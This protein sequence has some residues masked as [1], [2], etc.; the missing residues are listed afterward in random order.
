IYN[1]IVATSRPNCHLSGLAGLDQANI[2]S[3]TV[4][5]DASATAQYGARGSNGVILI[6]TKS[7]R[8]GKT[9]FSINSTYG[10]QNDAITGPVPLTAAER[11]ELLSE[12]YYNDGFFGSKQD[13]EAFLLGGSHAEWDANG[14]PEARWDLAVANR[15]AIIQQHNF[16]A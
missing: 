14:R 3:I 10:F 1:G 9:V 6:T 13:A 11:M 7:G 12:A 15:D 2:E 8:A 16:S 4:L 5:K